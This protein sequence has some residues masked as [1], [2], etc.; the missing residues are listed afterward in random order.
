MLFVHISL[1][2]K[3]WILC[4]DVSCIMYSYVLVCIIHNGMAYSIHIGIF[5]TMLLITCHNT[6]TELQPWCLRKCLR[7]I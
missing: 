5:I 1:E 7:N 4:N 2:R 6:W 3:E